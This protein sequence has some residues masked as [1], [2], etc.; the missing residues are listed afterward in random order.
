MRAKLELEPKKRPTQERGLATY[1]ALVEAT[2]LELERH[3]YEQLN[4]N[5]IARTAGAGV[6]S[7]YEYF[8][9]KH[10]LIAAVVT[11][12]LDAVIGEL[13]RGLEGVLVAS[14]GAAVDQW[15]ELMFKAVQKHGP[16][17]TVLVE[18][19]PF[20]WQVPAV[21]QARARLY[22]L[23]RA[24]RS[25]YASV[26]EDQLEGLT[27]LMPVIVSNAVLDAVVRSPSAPGTAELSHALSQAVRRMLA[28]E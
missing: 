3:G 25:L 16:L 20:L 15:I 2:A 8:P 23:S 19:V 17:I 5:H 18:E 9:G 14:L 28:L 10:A 13:E 22:E 11:D 26:P 24:A 21:Q 6:A 4:V 27:Y 7:L 12:V 1:R